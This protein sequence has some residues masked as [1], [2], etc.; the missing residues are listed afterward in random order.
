MVQKNMPVIGILTNILTIEKGLLTGKERIYV[1]RDYSNAVVQSAGVP[2]LLPIVPNKEIICRQIE[3]VDAILISGGQDIDPYHYGEDRLPQIQ[4]VCAERDSYEM[5]TIRYAF[6]RQK[7]ILGICRGLQI[8]N[9]AFGGSL[10]Q[11]IG[12]YFPKS[13]EHAQNEMSGR[14]H[15]IL[16]KNSRLHR[17]FGLESFQ[18]NSFHHQSIKEIAPGFVVNAWA[19]DGIIEGIEKQDDL[20]VMGVQWHPEMLIDHESMMLK[21]FSTFISIVS[22]DVNI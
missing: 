3:S 4:E 22:S 12:H 9:V 18:I 7:P 17:T 21:L 20:F 5:E 10:Y 2:L 11:D 8:L 13:L 14:H 19:P 1:N 16:E 6:S 15:V